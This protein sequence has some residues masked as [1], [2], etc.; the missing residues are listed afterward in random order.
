MVFWVYDNFEFI[1]I[2]NLMKYMVQSKTPLGSI[3]IFYAH[4]KFLPAY[5]STHRIFTISFQLRFVLC[6]TYKK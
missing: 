3:S 2:F 4:L 5:N 1:Y 6:Y